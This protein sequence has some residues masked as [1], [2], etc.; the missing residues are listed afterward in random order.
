MYA[1]GVGLVKVYKS[2]IRLA[3]GG[4]LCPPSDVCVRSFLC[5]FLHFHKTLLHKALEWSS[6]VPNPKAKSSSSEIT[7]LIPFTVNY[8]WAQTHV[9]WVGDAIQS[10]HPLSPPSPPALNLS[11]HQDFS[12]ESGLCISWPRYWSFSISPSNEYSGLI[13]FRSS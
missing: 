10:L 5:P 13:S 12:N 1:V 3:S 7:N 6:L 2:L 4:T 8:L 9:H 11:K